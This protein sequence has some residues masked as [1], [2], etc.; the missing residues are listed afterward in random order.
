MVRLMFANVSCLTIFPNFFLFVPLNTLLV[1][2]LLVLVAWIFLLDT[3]LLWSISYGGG[4]L[5]FK[6]SNSEV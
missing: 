4:I 1:V 3:I 2:V 6:E 5:F